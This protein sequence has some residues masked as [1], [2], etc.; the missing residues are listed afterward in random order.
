SSRSLQFQPYQCRWRSFSTSSGVGS[1]DASVEQTSV[2][3]AQNVESPVVVVTGASKGIGRAIALTM[4]KAGCKVL[5]N[6]LKSSK[7]GEEVSE[8]IE[9]Y[10]GQALPFQADASKEADVRSLIKA[11]VDSWG[12]I[13]V[14]INNAGIVHDG[15]LVRMNNSEGRQVFDVN[16][17]GKRLCTKAANEIMM[18][19]NK[20]RIINITSVVGLIGN[21]GQAD[22]SASAAAI[23]GFTRSTA[24]EYAR[25]NITVNAVA[26]G[27]ISTDMTAT[28]SEDYKKKIL[29]TIPLGRFGQPEE[30]AGL[31]KFLALHPAASYM[32]GGV[33]PIDGGL[34]LSSIL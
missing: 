5:V 32:T 2:T 3:V 6:Y 29:D 20:G 11:A 9:A 17:F 1:Q 12:T 22:Y 26:P 33:Y 25:R 16:F 4:G 13:D 31:V 8:E 24:K 30:V 19:K 27:F 14:L 18:T 34:S 23:K 7:N 21:V 15:L 28:L 10:G